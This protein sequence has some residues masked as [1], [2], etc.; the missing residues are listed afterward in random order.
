MVASCLSQYA[1]LVYWQLVV[2]GMPEPEVRKGTSLTSYANN[3]SNVM[4]CDIITGTIAI[5]RRSKDLGIAPRA[6]D[7][8]RSC[9]L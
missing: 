6:L 3:S 2:V 1:N 9:S 5:I 7:P 4:S 8:S